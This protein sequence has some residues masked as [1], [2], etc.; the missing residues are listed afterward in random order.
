[1]NSLLDLNLRHL[2]T[3]YLE[4]DRKARMASDLIGNN[5][6][7]DVYIRSLIDRQGGGGYFGKREQ[8]TSRFC[9]P[10]ASVL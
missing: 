6:A 9:G 10:P 4:K 1:M 2:T 3:W 5:H 7:D 8:T